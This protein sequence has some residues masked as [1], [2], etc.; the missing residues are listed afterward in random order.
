MSSLFEDES[1]GMHYTSARHEVLFGRTK[2]YFDNPVPSGNAIACRVFARLGDAARAGR[3]LEAGL[4]WAERAPGSTGA[5]LLAAFDC[6]IG[7]GWADIVLFGDKTYGEVVLRIPQGMHVNA[8]NPAAVGPDPLLVEFIGVEGE[9]QYPPT[10]GGT[11]TGEVRV[12]IRLGASDPL[13]DARV[14]VS[15]QPC[16]GSECLPRRTE[17]LSLDTELTWSEAR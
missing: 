10:A 6:G 2:P 4:G 11:Y 1:G 5:L 13:E 7:H 17:S 15:Y 12:P 8:G 14:S 16:S 9:A 3:I